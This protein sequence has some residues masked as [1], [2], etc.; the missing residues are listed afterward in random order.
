MR[1]VRPGLRTVVT[2]L[3][4]FTLASAALAQASVNYDLSWH[5]IAEGGGRMEGQ[6]HTVLGT[7]GQP[8]AGKLSSTGHTLDS[9]FWSRRAVGKH[10]IYLPAVL[11]Q[12]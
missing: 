1:R 4:L 12:G 11:R 6:N 10:D 2:T 7:I 9:G 8:I 3:V 5:V